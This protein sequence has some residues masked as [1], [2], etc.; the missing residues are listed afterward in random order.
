[1]LS[2]HAQAYQALRAQAA[3]FHEQ[4]LQALSDARSGFFQ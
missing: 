1:M 2:G 4:F 3:T